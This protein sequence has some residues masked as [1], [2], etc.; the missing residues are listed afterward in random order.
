MSEAYNWKSLQMLFESLNKSCR[1]LILRNF[2][3]MDEPDFFCN[4]HE[5]IDILCENYEKFK[6]AAKAENLYNEDNIHLYVMVNYRRIPIDLRT[7]GDDYYDAAWEEN[8]LSSRKLK[9]TM[10]GEWYTMDEEN[11]YYSLVYHAYIQK[12]MVGADYPARLQEL[13]RSIGLTN[14]TKEMHLESLIS[15]LNENEYM[16][17]Y[18]HD[19]SV[20][21]NAY[22][23]PENLI[24]REKEAWKEGRRIRYP[25]RKG[26][27]ICNLFT[28][29]LMEIKKYYQKHKM[30][31]E[32]SAIMGTILHGKIICDIAAGS[33]G[34]WAGGIGLILFLMVMG[35]ISCIFTDIWQVNCFSTMIWQSLGIIMC[36]YL[37]FLLTKEKGIYA[38]AII[39]GLLM[40]YRILNSNK[41]GMKFIGIALIIIVVI[42]A[43]CT[44]NIIYA[45]N[46]IIQLGIIG[47]Y[48]FLCHLLAGMEDKGDSKYLFIG[49]F[50][51]V[52]VLIYFALT[53]GEI[54]GWT[55]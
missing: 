3:N 21:V 29:A 9:H 39:A 4:G 38:L 12:E 19:I 40:A 20:P 47:G 45:T 52:I 7:V 27:A 53:T 6:T 15:F 36:P 22:L 23:L 37:A 50:I 16:C 26:I 17:P 34:P 41:K 11:Y 8:M 10:M 24:T 32:V 28:G 48:L 44:R 31:F 30:V 55:F 49:R 18:P 13:A 46:S 43:V 33:I 35:L 14:T 25:Y 54:Y 1:Y 2:E 42:V 5:D 51:Q